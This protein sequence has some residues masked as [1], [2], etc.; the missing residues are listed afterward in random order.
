MG[1]L[2]GD[3]REEVYAQELSRGEKMGCG[4]NRRMWL[5]HRKQGKEWPGDACQA[6]CSGHAWPFFDF[7]LNS[8]GPQNLVEGF[9]VIKTCYFETIVHTMYLYRK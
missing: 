3:N 7:R 1:I 6:G 4:R 2:Q 5:E 9:F 8:L